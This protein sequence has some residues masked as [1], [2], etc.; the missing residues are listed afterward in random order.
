MLVSGSP[1]RLRAAWHGLDLPRITGAFPVRCLPA[2]AILLTLAAT[3]GLAQNSTLAEDLKVGDPAPEFSL[4][5]TDG[6]TYTLQ[7]FLGKQ[8]VVIAWFPKAKT[9]G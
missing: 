2:A 4:P 5:G 7:D 1:C 3:L 9:G 8:A 6:E